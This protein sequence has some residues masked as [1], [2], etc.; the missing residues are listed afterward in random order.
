MSKT[1]LGIN[2]S[3]EASICQMT[4]K[5]ID[6]YKEETRERNDKYYAPY[7]S[8]VVEGKC[9]WKVLDK[10]VKPF[11]DSIDEISF[12][13]FDRRNKDLKLATDHYYEMQECYEVIRAELLTHDRIKTIY[14]QLSPWVT[15]EMVSDNEDEMIANA[16]MTQI[17]RDNYSFN[18]NE[19][20]LYHVYGGYYLS[21]WLD[22][23][24]DCIALIM[25]GG[26]AQRYAH[27]IP[28]YQEVESIYYVTPEKV[29]PQWCHLTN[30]R[31]VEEEMFHLKSFEQR[32][33]DCDCVFD[34]KFSMGQK[35][36]TL[37]ATLDFDEK[38][39]A[40]GKVMGF[41]A[42]GQYLKNH[43]PNEIQYGG[44][45]LAYQLQ[46]ESFYHTC[47]LINKAISYN[48]DCKRILLSGGYALNCTNNY[49]YTQAFPDYEFFVDPCAYDGGTAIGVAVESQYYG[50]LS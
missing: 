34:S 50:D 7:A 48:P 10:H 1:S 2:I 44:S 15:V 22:E 28:N 38:G 25:D 6:F 30:N 4:D 35:F 41:A 3:H 21:K 24:K 9:Q 31:A 12:A 45:A 47:G 27:E 36:S 20:H 29:T 39:R 26:G 23:D 13:S 37:S 17:G 5:K 42:M 49:R 16:L 33:D 32:W 14:N 19:H 46:E 40:A 18:Q 8:D 11:V 43:N